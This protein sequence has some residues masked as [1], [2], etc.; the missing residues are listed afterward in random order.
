MHKPVVYLVVVSTICGMTAR[1]RL[2]MAYL[3]DLRDTPQEPPDDRLLAR[4]IANRLEL[5]LTEVKG[6]IEQLQRKGYVRY[7][8]I[9]RR[10]YHRLTPRG[11]HEHEEH[12]ERTREY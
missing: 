6:D 3:Y 10:R 12:V 7:V 1:K 2:I 5:K 8:S 9:E 4:S 11:I